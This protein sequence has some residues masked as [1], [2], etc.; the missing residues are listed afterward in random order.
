MRD[1]RIIGSC[2]K[3]EAIRLL[4]EGTLKP[5]DQ[6]WEEGGPLFEGRQIFGPLEVLHPKFQEG[7]NRSVA[8]Y[9]KA[10]AGDPVGQR[11]FALFLLQGETTEYDISQAFNWFR[12][13]AEQ[14]DAIAQCNL[15]A[16]LMGGIGVPKDYVE[17]VMWTRKAAEQGNQYAQCNLAEAYAQGNG[18]QKDAIEASKW[19]LKSAEQGNAQAQCNI[20]AAYYNG[21]G[22]GKDVKEAIKWTRRSAEQGLVGSQY[23][24]GLMIGQ[25]QSPPDNVE[26]YAWIALAASK[27]LPEAK[28]VIKDL[29]GRWT[30]GDIL[31]ARNFT[32]TLSKRVELFAELLPKARAG[33][34]GAQRR[35]ADV[36]FN[37][38][39]FYESASW[40]TKAAEQGE[41]TAQGML[42]NMYFNG[43]GV[44][45][46]SKEAS[47][48]TRT[49]AESGCDF[50]Q[51]NLG[52]DHFQG[53]GVPVDFA[54]ADKWFRKAAEQ[55]FASAQLKLGGLLLMFRAPG[56]DALGNLIDAYAWLSLFCIEDGKERKEEDILLARRTLDWL[57][58]IP[59]VE[60]EG[61]K[62][63]QELMEKLKLH[64]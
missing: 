48:W 38:A 7:L 23:N 4:V 64:T 17:G 37:S 42:G 12:K 18:L 45:K 53:R 62:R 14:G 24:L 26:V 1:D 47:K 22:V 29:E 32:K 49:A 59:T 60:V 61:E 50:A 43:K 20:G 21:N 40:Y 46:D 28:E 16:R 44:P 56:A 31:A 55:G 54:E 2:T 30:Q 51:Y 10:L 63:T 19:Y 34:A 25:N 36:Y 9:S 35:L 39:D 41:P 3:E 57:K 6:Y 13:A 11:E 8:L 58:E 15:G 52:L 33:D 27:G 5:T